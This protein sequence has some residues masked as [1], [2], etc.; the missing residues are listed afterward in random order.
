MDSLAAYAGHCHRVKFTKAGLAV[1]QDGQRYTYFPSV[2]TEAAREAALRIFAALKT[3]SPEGSKRTL[4]VLDYAQGGYVWTK[5]WTE[6][7]RYLDFWPLQERVSMLETLGRTSQHF[8]DMRALQR[9]QRKRAQDAAEAARAAE[10][11]RP[12]EKTRLQEEEAEAKQPLRDAELEAY[13]KQH[14]KKMRHPLTGEV[15]WV[16]RRQKNDE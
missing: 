12:Y 10:D 9:V 8:K 15:H 14:Y 7:G 6:D 3:R 11:W 16:I 2:H 13:R 5:D 1:Q 4:Y